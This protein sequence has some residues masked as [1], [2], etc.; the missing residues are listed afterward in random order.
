MPRAG[1]QLGGAGVQRGAPPQSRETATK[2]K[3]A[4]QHDQSGPCLCFACWREVVRHC[5]LCMG[6]MG[7][8]ATLRLLASLPAAPAEPELGAGGG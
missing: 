7:R 3:Q 1:G 8:E 5:D 4:A 6:A 2:A